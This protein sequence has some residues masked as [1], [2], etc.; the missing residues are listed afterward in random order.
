M[1][2][3]I[4]AVL[5]RSARRWALAADAPWRYEIAA[6]P[7][8]R[9][10]VDGHPLPEGEGSGQRRGDMKSPQHTSR[11]GPRQVGAGCPC[12]GTRPR[13]MTEKESA[14]LKAGATKAPPDILASGKFLLARPLHEL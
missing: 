3:N 9:P 4:R 11:A 10:S 5:A 12:Y 7:L 2:A 13:H 14:G 1:S 6:G 8:T